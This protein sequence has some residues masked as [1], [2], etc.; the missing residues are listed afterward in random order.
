MPQYASGALVI[1]I[2]RD[3]SPLNLYIGLMEN[4]YTEPRKPNHERFFDNSQGKIGKHSLQ[5]RLD[6]MTELGPWLDDPN[7]ENDALRRMLKD[8]LDFDFS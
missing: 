7:I 2:M 1:K 5:N 4:F 3:R 8:R 6:L